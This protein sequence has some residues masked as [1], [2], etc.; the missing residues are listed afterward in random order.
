[1]KFFSKVFNVFVSG[2]EQNW[3]IPKRGLDH[4]FTDMPHHEH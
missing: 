3:I 1:M 2:I 4:L